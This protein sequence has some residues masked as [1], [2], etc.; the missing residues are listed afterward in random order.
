[1][2]IVRELVDRYCAAWSDPDA[3]RRRELL[4]SIWSERAAYTDP[5]VHA[6]SAEELLAHVGRV[7]ERR[8][9]A[10]VVRTSEI[11]V[12]HDWCRFAWHVVQP[13][14]TVLRE[15]IDIVELTADGTR[16]A[17]I[18]GFFGSPVRAE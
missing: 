3:Q 14:G 12:H 4:A 17:R 15:G 5:T 7:L 2:S 18:I 13:D 9:G 16:I 10:K 1:M 6:A 8:P 11:D